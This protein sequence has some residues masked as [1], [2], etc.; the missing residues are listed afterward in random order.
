MV[1]HVQP[2]LLPLKDLRLRQRHLRLVCE[3]RATVEAVSVGSGGESTDR[4]ADGDRV[5]EFGVGQRVRRHRR[6]RSGFKSERHAWD[7]KI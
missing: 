2:L 7:V 4:G 5:G 1:Q 6:W 3:L